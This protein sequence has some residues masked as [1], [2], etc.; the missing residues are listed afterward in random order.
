M[1]LTTDDKR[2]L[3]GEEGEG[4]ALAMRV[5]VGIGEAFDAPRLVDV[6]RTHVALSNQEADTW[7]AKRLADGGARAR[8]APTVNPG[9][10]IDYFEA[11]TELPEAARAHM[12]LTDDT[13]RRLG[14][15]LTYNCTPY[16]D[17]NI[18][19]QGEI[20]AFSESSATPFVNSVWGA[21]TNRESS[22]SALCSAVTGRTPLYG[23][24]LDENR[25]GEV[26]VDVQAELRDEFDYH[27]LGYV[28]PAKTGPHAPV[29]TGIPPDVTPEALMNLGAQLNTAGAVS[30]YHI[31][32]VTPEAPTVEAALGGR[33]AL[34][35]VSVND[36]DLR[37]QREALSEPAGAVDF[38]MLGCPHLTVR[39]VADIARAVEGK[40]LRAELW[41]CTSF[42]TRE[43]LRP[44]GLAC[45]HRGSG[46]ARLC[47][48]LHRSALL[49]PPHRQEGHDRLA[50]MPLLREHAR[51]ELRL[52]PAQRLRRGGDHGTGDMSGNDGRYECRGIVHGRTSG[53]ILR[54]SD[55][56]CFYLVDPTSGVM[57]EKGHP[58]NGRSIAGTVLVFPT[59]KGSSVVQLDG[60]Y[61]LVKHG[62]APRA[63]VVQSP[64]TVLVACAVIMEIPLVTDVDATFDDKVL[65]GQQVAVD[66]DEGW[67]VVQ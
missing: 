42:A 26:I 35:R 52:G 18:P 2:M 61:Q 41:I 31:V 57:T 67:L 7:F 50:Q 13:Y 44:D 55:G 23:L 8:V 63:I 30:M 10:S 56:I 46:R 43:V 65:D 20:V 6:T 24:L 36:D 9:F 3:E 19:R 45:V 28:V 14:A 48:H 49:A 66:A 40:S 32:G 37:R 29:F 51:H 4:T 16:L 22:Q 33:E 17:L 25:H 53:D 38:V 47:R 54:S 64:D 62:V 39:Q 34:S 1:D 27:L 5:L 60:L 11:H 59:G 21:R 58:L 15:R 12:Q